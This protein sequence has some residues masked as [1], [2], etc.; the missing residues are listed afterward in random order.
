MRAKVIDKNFKLVN[1]THHS[2]SQKDS[3]SYDYLML[4]K[5]ASMGYYVLTPIL[6]GVFF[7]LGIDMYFNTRPKATVGMLVFGVIASFYNLYKIVRD[8]A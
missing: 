7:G 4:A 1:Q 6:L 3:K 8:G 2:T 5:Y